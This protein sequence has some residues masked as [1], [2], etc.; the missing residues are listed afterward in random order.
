MRLGA[1]D[2]MMNQSFG[3][4]SVTF[5][6]RDQADAERLNGLLGSAI[7]IEVQKDHPKRSTEANAYLWVLLGKL[8]NKLR[9]NPVEVYRQYIKDVG[10]NYEI[11]PVKDVAVEKFKEVWTSKGYGWICE[12]H[13]ES[14]FPGYTNLICFYGSSTYDTAQMSKMIDMVV[15]DCKE[16]GIETLPEEELK[17]IIGGRG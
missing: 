7:T 6:V 9:S 1:D 4:V 14:R 5:A 13:S 12:K 8:A 16:Q 3:Q 2:W 17:S 15:A 10:N 11:L